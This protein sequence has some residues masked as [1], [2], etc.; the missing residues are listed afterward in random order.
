MD[1]DFKNKILSELTDIESMHIQ[2]NLEL[3]KKCAEY[4]GAL[5]LAWRLKVIDWDGAL[6]LFG[7]FT[8]KIMKLR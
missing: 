2:S 8:V 6:R 3:E 4:F 5:R 1:E 7:E